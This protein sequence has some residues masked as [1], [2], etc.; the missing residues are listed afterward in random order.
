M[1][2]TSYLSSILGNHAKKIGLVVCLSVALISPSWGLSLE[3]KKGL[4]SITILKP[5]LYPETI[6]VNRNNGRFLV[7]S[8]REGAIYEVGEDGLYRELVKDERLNSV[9]GITV[10]YSRNV[11]LAANSDIGASIRS[12]EKGPKT[13]ASVGIY[14]LT[15]GNV[16]DYVN[17]GHL[18]PT[19]DHLVN[20]ITLDS[21]G[22]AYVTDSFSSTIYKIDT[23]G[24]ASVFLKSEKFDGSGISLNGIVYHPDDY[25]LVIK[26][27]DGA[28]FKIPLSKPD[29]FTKVN[30]QRSFIGGD[31]ISLLSNNE[32]VIV[33]NKASGVN[34]NSVF[35]VKS[36]DN[37]L[38]ASVSDSYELED[39]YPTTGVVKN[40]KFYV[41]HSNL[42]K[43]IKSPN[44]ARRALKKEATILQ[45]GIVTP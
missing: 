44:E 36:S 2:L 13:L 26:K 9:L 33:A 8:F 28:L 10:D 15:T 45:V 40:D 34:S 5:A 18:Q 17:L 21:V 4:G 19:K 12:Q 1:N 31:G 32:I 42:D 7:G 11:I 23:E 39:V 41:L 22:N 35:L 37:W 20:G 29:K 14:D 6:E 24:K 38:S 43:L 27:N 25:L 16:I 3:L 30:T